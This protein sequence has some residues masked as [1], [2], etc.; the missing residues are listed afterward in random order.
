MLALSLATRLAASL[1]GEKCAQQ[2]LQ[3]FQFPSRDCAQVIV[4]K[5]LSLGIIAGSALVK[6]P[7]IVKILLSQSVQGLSF[8]AFLL[9]MMASSITFA[10][11]FRA[12]NSFITY[13]ETLFVT[14]QNAL[15]VLLIGFYGNKMMQLLVITALYSV[16]LSTLLVP[17]YVSDELMATLQAATIPLAA[18]ARLPQ[19]LQILA[20][21][22]TGQ[23]SS[24]SVFLIAA[25]SL[26]R[27][28]TTVAEVKDRLLVAGFAV[29]AGL[30]VV[31]F[32]Q[33]LATPK[34]KRAKKQKRS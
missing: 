29:S 32:L 15:I 30:N 25:G 19:I 11:N 16:F 9:E 3:D 24:L 6:V 21:G 12:G 2:I 8:L 17:Q 22:Q 14:L 7:Q 23:L 5:G 28:Y 18:L 13:G 1:I 10:Y 26:A 31:L 20:S 27:L 33:V 4:R 34:H